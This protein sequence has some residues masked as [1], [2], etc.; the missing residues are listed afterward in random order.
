MPKSAET[1]RR[2]RLSTGSAPDRWCERRA[3]TPYENARVM[4]QDVPDPV[5]A[6]EISRSATAIQ[7]QRAKI[8]HGGYGNGSGRFEVAS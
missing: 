2:W 1:R 3:W 7:T 4:A 6:A 8:K 5:L